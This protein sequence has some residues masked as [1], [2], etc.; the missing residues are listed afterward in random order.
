[1]LGAALA[2]L[3]VGGVAC[4]GLGGPGGS[5]AGP[6][7]FDSGDKLTTTTKE[8]LVIGGPTGKGKID[9]V[10]D[11]H[12]WTFDGK[13]GQSVTITA[14]GVSGSDP[15]LKLIDPSG[16]VLAEDD[17]AGGG[18]NAQINI[19]LPVTGTYT[20]RIDMMEI[21]EYTIAVR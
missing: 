6:G 16:A 2:L 20:L 3:L 14:A 9:T 17:D 19:D 4:S 15:Y 21:G 12:D 13:A 11:A 8:P 18:S 7:K 1:L 10:F 5:S